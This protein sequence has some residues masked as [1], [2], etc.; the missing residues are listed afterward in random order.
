MGLMR[1]IASDLAG[2]SK[3]NINPQRIWAGGGLGEWGDGDD[4]AGSRGG[5][6][7]DRGRSLPGGA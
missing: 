5:A 4:S 3:A 6:V 1:E 2:L 7:G